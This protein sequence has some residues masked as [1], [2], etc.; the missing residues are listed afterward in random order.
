MIQKTSQSF[1]NICLNKW[2]G[3]KGLKLLGEKGEEA[4]KNELQQ[5]HDMDGFTPKH[6]HQLTK[7]ERVRALKY[8]MYLKEKRDRKVKGRGC[9]DRRPQQLYTN[10]NETSSPTAALPA[11][12]L[13]C[14]IDAFEKRDIATVDIPGV[15]LQTKISKEEHDVH[16]ILE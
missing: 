10:K 1:L 5:I 11:I 3:K 14:T 7:E 6:W 13:T 15:S 16:V 4:I 12:M 2:V 8:L 9:A